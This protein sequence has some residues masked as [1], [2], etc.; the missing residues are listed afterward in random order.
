MAS[1]WL[2][3]GHAPVTGTVNNYQNLHTNQIRECF[4]RMHSPK[5]TLTSK[6]VSSNAPSSTTEEHV[7]SVAETAVIST[8][9]SACIQLIVLFLCLPRKPTTRFSGRVIRI[10]AVHKGMPGREIE[11]KG[12]R[13]REK[14]T[15]KDGERE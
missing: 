14:V 5:K 2:R 4:L 11:R 7:A 15:E 8:V 6:V 1:C 12:V 9:S 13:Q 3:L 10:I